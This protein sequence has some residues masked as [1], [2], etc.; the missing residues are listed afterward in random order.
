[1]PKLNSWLPQGGE[2][3]FQKVKRERDEALKKGVKLWPLSF[4]QPAGAALLSARKKAS[5]AVMSEDESMHEYQD[6]GSLGI[7]DFAK[8]FI[9][10]HFNKETAEKISAADNKGNLDFL[11]TP[12]TK[13]MLGLIPMAS[14]F[15]RKNNENQAHNPSLKIATMTEPGYPTPAV[16]C[17]YLGADN[18]ALKTDP[19]NN[20][21][22]SL[23]DIRPETRLI[24]AN[25]PHNPSG[26]V[27]DK[28]FWRG[29]CE[30][31]VKNN[32][33]LF[34]DA[35]YAILTFTDTASMLAETAIEFPGLSWA[36]AYSSSKVIANGT[37]WRIGAIIGSRDFM[38]DIRT[39][40]GNTDSG[41][42]APAAAGVLTA[43]EE[44]MEGIIKNRSMYARRLKLLIK[45]LTER[46]MKP[47]VIPEATFFT[48]WLTPKIAFGR[49]I[50]SASEFNKLMIEKTGVVG[51]P[52][53]PYLRYTVTNPIENEEWT[54]AIIKAFD[55]AKI[56]Y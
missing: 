33:R 26:Q 3:I 22:F 50:N 39:I 23:K 31:C 51:I 18:Y 15:I 25:Y 21:I 48:I 49:E 29:L 30:Y 14:G 11:P 16:W 19:K 36:E 13:S 53:E 5:E 37:G 34:N 2:N 20:F 56:S 40:K 43:M 41:F 6:N 55:Q 9:I 27:V 24:M 46:G 35:A 28:K 38:A 52:F 54:E 7:K 12:G 1:M 45:L 10:A 47:A 8:R 44:D 17:D 42:F 4:G 32:I